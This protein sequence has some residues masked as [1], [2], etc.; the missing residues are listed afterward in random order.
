M[1]SEE[2]RAEIDLEAGKSYKLEVRTYLDPATLGA[3]PFAIKSSFRIGAFPTIHTETA[4]KEAVEL[5]S[6]SDLAIVVVGTNPD[7]ESEGFDRKDAKLPGEAD[8]LVA[9][10]LKVNP[11]T[12][13]VNQ[14]GTPVEFPW[15]KDAPTL[16]QAFFGGNE[17]GNGLAD[18]LFG[19]VNPSSKL[20]LTF[21]F[22]F[23]FLAPF[24]RP[25]S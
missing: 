8:E 17:L 18:V 22:V 5:A 4:R 3:S 13:V 23:S 14:S 20:P 15:I 7:W 10:V 25:S 24:S 19:K 9:A 16:V 1:G 6:Q 12:I 21:P 11:N 2:L